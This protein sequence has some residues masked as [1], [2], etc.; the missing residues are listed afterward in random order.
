MNTIYGIIPKLIG[1]RKIAIDASDRA[2]QK[3][4]M[5]KLTGTSMDT[6]KNP[7]FE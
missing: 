7:D 5:P 1:P 3:E 6:R 2:T 4:M